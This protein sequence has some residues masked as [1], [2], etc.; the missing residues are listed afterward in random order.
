VTP[1]E[2]RALV[3]AHMPMLR[4]VAWE[5]FRACKGR[6]EFDDLVGA[7]AV[8]LC[9]AARRYRPGKRAFAAFAWARIRGSIVDWMRRDGRWNRGQVARRRISG[10]DEVCFVGLSVV[11]ELPDQA[12]PIDEALSD[13]RTLAMARERIAGM[14]PRTQRIMG[15]M[16]TDGLD[17]KAAGGVMGISKTRVCQLRRAAI[18]EL[19]EA[20]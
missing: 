12:P 8:G 10:V 2:R 3:E 20:A 18:Q 16:Y 4:S 14:D 1:A 9:Q 5:F 11:A 17:G 15:L 13:R 7:G 6:W 19:Q